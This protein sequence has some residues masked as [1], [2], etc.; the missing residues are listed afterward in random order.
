MKFDV[1]INDLNHALSIVK[2]TIGTDTVGHLGIRVYASK[3][4]NKI[5]LT[6]TDGHYFTETWIPAS[7]K[8]TGKCVIHANKFVKYVNKL[9][10]EKATFSLKPNGA[11]H[12]KSKR[13]QQ[14]FN[15]FDESMFNTPPKLTTEFS[16]HI[17]GHVY[18]QLINSV[19]FATDN[20]K[21]P[22]RPILAGIHLSSDGK[23]LEL[24][25]TNGLTVAHHR[26]KLKSKPLDVVLGKKSLVN[27]AKLVGDDEKVTVQACGHNKFVI[28]VADTT[29]YLPSLAGNFPDVK[30]IL[31]G[32]EF[33]LEFMAD[34]DELLGVLDR[35]SLML[36]GKGILQFEKGKVTIAG[37]NQETEFAEYITTNLQGEASDVRVDMKKLAEI[38]KHIDADLIQVGIRE[39]QP[40]TLRPEGRI[41]HTCI[42]AVG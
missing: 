7:V 14:T 3:K 39:K 42:L 30:S 33:A 9:D 34:K 11:I 32:R 16:F 28:K 15:S 23:V 19:A 24:T 13:G 35:A 36:D 40:I 4:S 25:S 29:Y 26:K 18:K 20:S 10:A 38:I 27:S 17:A 8:E 2:D 41:S 21:E 1:A 12:M 22:T 37:Q 5:K 6:T 31:P